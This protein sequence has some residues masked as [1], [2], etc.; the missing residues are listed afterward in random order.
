MGYLKVAYSEKNVAV[1]SRKMDNQ[2]IYSFYFRNKAGNKHL[3]KAKLSFGETHP[4]GMRTF[5]IERKISL[6][7]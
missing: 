7:A 5:I 2:K 4:Q 6:Q 1:S 3:E